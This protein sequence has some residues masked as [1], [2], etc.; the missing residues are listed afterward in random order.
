MA[1]VIMRG[2]VQ[3]SEI[4]AGE[5]VFVNSASLSMWFGFAPRLRTVFAPSGEQKSFR[6]R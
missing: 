6:H 5:I 1:G 3:G 2:Q 4:R